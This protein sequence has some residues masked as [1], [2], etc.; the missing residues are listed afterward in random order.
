MAVSAPMM[1]NGSWDSDHAMVISKVKFTPTC[2]F[3]TVTFNAAAKADAWTEFSVH[4]N[5][6]LINRFIREA[7]AVLTYRREGSEYR[8]HVTTTDVDVSWDSFHAYMS[9]AS[10]TRGSSVPTADA[11]GKDVFEGLPSPHD[12]KVLEANSRDTVRELPGAAPCPTGPC[13]GC[14]SSQQ[15]HATCGLGL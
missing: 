14:S 4:P 13:C 6:A 2:E 5:D 7:I 11:P 12:A 15:V 3:E 8:D 9:S 10:S 1:P